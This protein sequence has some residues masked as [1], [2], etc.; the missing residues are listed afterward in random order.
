MHPSGRLLM[1]QGSSHGIAGRGW[2][3]T[4][5]I[6]TW[7]SHPLEVEGKVSNVVENIRL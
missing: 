6:G 7:E 4:L 3:I 2:G 1:R 5:G